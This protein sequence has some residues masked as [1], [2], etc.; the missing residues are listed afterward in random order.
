MRSLL[1]VVVL[2]LAA[3]CCAGELRVDFARPLGKFRPLQGVN[4]G[5]VNQGGTVDLSASWK[6]LQIPMTR[7]HDCEWPSGRVV[8]MHSVF[9][10]LKADPRDA[11]SYRFA[12]TDDYLAAI[13]KINAR[14]VYRLGESIE[15]TPRKHHVHPPRDYDAWARACLGVIRHYNEGWADGF[16]HD[17]RYWEIWNEPE[18]RPACWTGSDADYYRLYNTTAKAIKKEFPDVKVGG[19][20]VGAT[21]EVQDDKW[22]PTE[23]VQGFFASCEQE[24]T[25]LDF[26]SWHTYTNDPSVYRRKAVAMR[27]WLNERGLQQTELHLNEWNYLP[28]NDWSGLA[29]QSQGAARA[30][31]FA[32]QG[33]AEGAA[34]VASVL[35]DLQDSPVD[36]ANFFHGDSSSFGLFTQ[37]GEPKATYYAMLACHALASQPVRVSASGGEEG[38]VAI[39]AGIDEKQ[40]AATLLIANFRSREERFTISLDGL[41]WPAATRCELRRIDAEQRLDRLTVATM[42]DHRLGITLPAPSVL[43]VRLSPAK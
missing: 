15:H 21:G 17:I 19:P 13:V 35:L 28:D 39:A 38:R 18:N 36:V 6:E 27:A 5:P 3:T 9:P 43:L 4:G 23:F 12:E 7:L 26:F 41:P 8:D 24:K 1:V 25:P 31:W 30:K 16:Q 14:I 42:K 40:Q 2:G 37:H 33:G 22:R 34:F 29:P 32:R 11:A 10:D 20:A